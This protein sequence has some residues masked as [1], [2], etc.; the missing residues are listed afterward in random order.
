MKLL[1]GEKGDKRVFK[2]REERKRKGEMIGGSRGKGVGPGVHWI[3]SDSYSYDEVKRGDPNIDQ[4]WDGPYYVILP[5]LCWFV[6][7]RAMGG[8]K[9]QRHPTHTSPSFQS[10]GIFCFF[11]FFFIFCILIFYVSRL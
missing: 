10:I 3:W 8:Y 1:K 6:L 5:P 7:T 4:N 2:G 9:L 11:L